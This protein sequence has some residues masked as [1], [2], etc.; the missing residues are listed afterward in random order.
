MTWG[1]PQLV[2]RMRLAGLNTTALQVP[3]SSVA[4]NAPLST[5][6][7]FV[8]P[9]SPP[10]ARIRPS[11]SNAAADTGLSWPLIVRRHIPESASQRRTVRSLDGVASR[12][13]SGSGVPIRVML[14]AAH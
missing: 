12:R 14:A 5:S 1:G 11:R 2:A 10:V 3:L 13:P 6:H 9:S 4:R 7:N 8:V